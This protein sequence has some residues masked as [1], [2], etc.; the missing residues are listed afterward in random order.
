M[1]L[2]P[3]YVFVGVVF[4]IVFF[5]YNAF[6]IQRDQKLFDAYYCQTIGCANER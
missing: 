3:K 1:N 2:S 5:G 4:L 6:L